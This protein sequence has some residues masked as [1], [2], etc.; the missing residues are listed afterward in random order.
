MLSLFCDPSVFTLLFARMATDSLPVC[1]IFLSSGGVKRK[2]DI[3]LGSA[4]LCLPGKDVTVLSS[5]RTG[6]LL[7]S[8]SHAPQCRYSKYITYSMTEWL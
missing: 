7:C 5:H 6:R 4:H 2:C 3:S 8:Y 1:F